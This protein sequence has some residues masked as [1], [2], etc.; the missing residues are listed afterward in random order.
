M[1]SGD[2]LAAELAQ[3]Y[4]TVQRARG[5]F[6][7]TRKGVR[8]T[9]MYQEGGRAI[10]GWRGTSFTVFK[11]VMNRGATGSFDTDCT[12]RIA[13]AVCALLGDVRTVFICENRN[14]ALALALTFSK[15]RT[16]FWKA[17]SDIDWHAADCVVI[18]PP[19]PWASSVH[20]V[21]VKSE[22][23]EAFLASGFTSPNNARIAAPLAAGIA[24][25][26]YDMIATIPKRTEKDWFLYDTVLTNYWT[27]TGPYLY[28][29]VAESTYDDFVRHCLDCTLVVSPDY[30]V[31]SIVPFG[32]DKG[33]FTKL[34][35]APFEV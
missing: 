13:K 35:N 26:L 3:R 8:L 32:V 2:F 28:P 7:Y 25:A 27:R 31:P 14:A 4:G 1:A 12:P 11:N 16:S 21:A 22:V 10:L 24:R 29:K 17:W 34:K 6:L 19:F 18:V 30:N 23:H 15:E 5:Y 9:D 20:L 33:V